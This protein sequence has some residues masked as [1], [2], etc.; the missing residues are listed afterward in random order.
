MT[1][2]ID[3]ETLDIKP[4][5]WQEISDILKGYAPRY[6]VWAFGSRVNG[7]ARQFSDLDL[8]IITKH[9]MPL[10]DFAIIKEAFEQSNL[11]YKVDL[12]DWAATS[13]PFQNIIRANKVIIQ[14]A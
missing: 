8:A 12:I 2:R 6:E 4:V 5:E 7:T 13:V 9:P 14:S 11:P 1:R 10:K 3:L